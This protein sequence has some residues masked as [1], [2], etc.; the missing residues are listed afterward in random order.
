MARKEFTYRGKNLKE[1]QSLSLNDFME[2]L[3][4]RQRRSLKRGFTKEEKHLLDELKKRDNVKT[5]CRELVILPEM[6]GKTILVY[7]GKTFNKVLITEEMIGH[8]IGEFSSSRPRVT[9][10]SPGVGATKSS[11]S[12]S[13]K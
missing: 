2:L 11:G 3:P 10:S 4:S 9:H 13:V 6:I 7:N 1:L 5:H 12:A 8:V